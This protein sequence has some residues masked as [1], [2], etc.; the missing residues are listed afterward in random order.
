M[1]IQSGINQALSVAGFL[2]PQTQWGQKQ[3]A[4]Q[5]IK[6][7]EKKAEFGKATD[8][9]AELA[10]QRDIA[11]SGREAYRNL[12]NIEP[13]EAAYQGIVK[14][15]R[16]ILDINQGSFAMDTK[17]TSGGST[18]GGSIW[19]RLDNAN[20]QARSSVMAEQARFAASPM[21]F[22][23]SEIDERARPR[24]Q[25]AIN[26]AQRDTKYLAKKDEQNQG[27]NQ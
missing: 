4:L 7:Y 21:I 8:D 9:P 12:F 19:D 2:L 13:S 24:V 16:D 1:S 27:G 5:D 10:A 6:A 20:S 26:R 17:K 22:D 15:N 23:L 11:E 25:R 3:A 18:G 14:S